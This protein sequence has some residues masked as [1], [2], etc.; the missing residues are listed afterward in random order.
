[1]KSA[2]FV[3]LGTAT[4]VLGLVTVLAAQQSPASK[5]AA[6]TTPA[7]VQAK[8]PTPQAAHNTSAEYNELVKRYCAG[9]HNDRTKER[10]G[11]LTL[12][13]FDMAKLGEHTDLGE[14]MIRKLQA[15]MMPPPGMPR[16]D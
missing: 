6:A 11:N 10:A 7:A 15:S 2:G 14:R 3:S 5:P 9:C 8:A 4:A 16:P 13:S 1:M 12:A